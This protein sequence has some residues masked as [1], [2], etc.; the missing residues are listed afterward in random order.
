M[1]NRL[2]RN[3]MFYGWYI[4]IAGV[5]MYSYNSAIN[6]YG[7]TAFIDPIATTFGWTYAQISLATSLRGIQGGALTPVMGFLVDRFPARRL[8]FWG[9]ITL[10]AGYFLMSRATNLFMFYLSFII[11]GLG[12]SLSISMVPQTTVARWFKKDLGKASG[13]LFTGNGLGGVFI[14][15][16]VSGIDHYGWRT[17]TLFIALGFILFC[18]PLSMI[19]RNRP[20]EYGL[21][22]DGKV[23]GKNNQKESGQI[24]IEIPDVELKDV[25]KMRAFWQLLLGITIQIGA[26]VSMTT[27]LM[28]YL[29]SKGLNRSVGGMITTAIPIV[30][31]LARFPIGWL[32]DFFDKRYILSSSVMLVSLS[33]FLFLAIDGDSYI[34]IFAYILVAGLTAGGLM[35]VRMPIFREYFGAKNFGKIY[36]LGTFSVIMGAAIGPPIAGRVYDILGYYE[37]IWLIFGICGIVGAISILTMPPSESSK[38]KRNEFLTSDKSNI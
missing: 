7:F 32:S 31:L 15:L 10:A 14:P 34:L 23:P 24:I 25:F 8:A 19:F 6:F 21:F 26:W 3:R 29:A 1:R 12:G 18:L 22:P 4:V 9:I 38:Q 13:L 16:I 5:L 17:T 37:P 33:Q 20:E 11:M 2:R 30:S 35:T 27:H 28:P 36:G